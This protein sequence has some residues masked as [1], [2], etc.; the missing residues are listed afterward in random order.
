MTFNSPDWF[1]V[2][3]NIA[4][5]ANGRISA[6]GYDSVNSGNPRLY[7][8]IINNPNPA[9]PIASI[10]LSWAVGGS[11]NAH[12]AIF[13]VN[14][15]VLNGDPAQNF[16]GNNVVVTADSTI[17]VRPVA[18]ATLGNVSIGTN[19]LTATGIN[20]TTLALGGINMSG[21]PT[22]NVAAGLTASAGAI[23]DG[24]TVRTLTKAGAGTLNLGTASPSLSAGAG[25]VV[26]A[27][28]VNLNNATALGSAANLTVNGGTFS[29]GAGV[30]PTLASLGGTS[31]SVALNGNTLTLGSASA[32]FAGSIA[33][34]SAPG[35]LVKS[36][37]GTQTLA[38]ASSY[39]GGTTVS[40]GTLAVTG[41]GGLGTGP[42]NLTG[43]TLSVA[44]GPPVVTVTGF[45]GTGTGWTANG[46]A[47]FPGADVLEL[48]PNAGGSAGSAWNNVAVPTRGFTA[49]FTYTV[50]SASA[51]PADGITFTLQNQGLNALGVGGGGLG[52]ETIT[53]SAA[54]AINIYPPN[55]TGGVGSGIKVLTNGQPP[56]GGFLP[57]AP[58]DPGLVSTPTDVDVTYDGVNASVTFNQN[59][60]TFSSGPIP[61]DIGGTAGT[62]A[63]LGFTGATG[64]L[65]A[66]QQ[67]SNFNFS[68]LP[69]NVYAND[70][71]VAAGSSPT[72]NVAATASVFNVTMGADS[73][74]QFHSQRGRRRFHASRSSLWTDFRCGD[75]ERS[76]HHQ[77][78][79]QRHRLWHS[80]ARCGGRTGFT[81]KNR[82]W[83]LGVA[84]CRD[85]HGPHEHQR[86]P[87]DRHEHQRVRHRCGRGQCEFRRHAGR[88]RIHYRQ[89]PSE[90]RGNDRAGQPAI[91][92]GGAG[93]SECCQRDI[94]RRRAPRQTQWQYA[95]HG[96]RSTFEH[97]HCLDRDQCRGADH[98]AGLCTIRR[99]STGHRASRRGVTRTV[100]WFAEQSSVCSRL[101]RR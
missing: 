73:W 90:F 40:A 100:H 52:Y 49:H 54:L 26:S 22:L 28:T 63:L 79:R 98:I 81:H 89:Y 39:S 68:T 14:T 42:V 55:T 51:P 16:G 65:Q 20:G 41:A 15:P 36:G 10:D 12:T 47:S 43:G 19:T 96:A 46:T 38:G 48:T 78:R 27:G 67:I 30:S 76:E 97:R 17:D 61:L 88:H 21:N 74:R 64:G 99:R 86:R 35:S 70:V 85:L 56:A 5:I 34:G 45:G 82:R 37:A 93:H 7:D 8:A 77:R 57:I 72:I 83:R 33:N 44:G 92:G 66:Q 24:G 58:V 1:F 13:G 69:L 31:G 50:P 95:R 94:H 80:Y 4:L 6:G 101:L 87:T 71:S 9:N 2:N 23:S 29:L 59:G 75:A 3:A 60:N 32:S 25:F 18:G 11:A 84:V 62:T 91:P 53:P